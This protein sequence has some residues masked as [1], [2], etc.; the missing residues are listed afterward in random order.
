MNRHRAAR[1]DKGPAEEEHLRGGH[2]SS[3]AG[4]YESLFRAAYPGLLRYAGALTH[5][6]ALAEDLVQEAF[7]R[8]WRQRAAL[9]PERSLQAWLYVTVRN[10]A[11]DHRRSVTTQRALRE[12]LAPSAGSPAAPEAEAGTEALEARLRGWIDELPVR[13]REAFLLSRFGGFTYEEI[14]RIMEVSVKTVDNHIWAAL[15]HLRAR[16]RAYEPDLLRP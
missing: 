11:L 6:E 3:G 2:G 9:D 8:L 1:E 16:L 13:R 15:Q 4:A 10:L 12:T 7:L 5:D 14:A